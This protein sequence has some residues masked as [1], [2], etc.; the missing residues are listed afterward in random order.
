[1]N[2]K[3]STKKPQKTITKTTVITLMQVFFIYHVQ[4]MLKA[5]QLKQLPL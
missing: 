5:E 3:Q 2:S 1:M 4:N